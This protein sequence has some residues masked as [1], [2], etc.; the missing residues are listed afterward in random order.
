M[1][2]IVRETKETRVEIQLARADARGLPPKV[3]V[4]TTLPFFD[5]M[6]GTLIKYAGLQAEVKATGD[7]QHHLMEDVALTLG[8]AVREVTPTAAARFGERTIVMDDALV[9]AAIDVG[10]RPY[11]VGELPNRLY[12]HVLRSFSQELGAGL[13]VRILDGQDRHHIIEAAFKA[14]GL[15]LR[16]ALGDAG[17]GIFSTKG[18]V[19]LTIEDDGTPGEP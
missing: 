6:L 16:Q 10:G 19:A 11:F 15:A 17:D 8:R 14:T 5:H 1:K 2:R 3:I 4:D 18:S 13:H 9:F 7:L 12:T